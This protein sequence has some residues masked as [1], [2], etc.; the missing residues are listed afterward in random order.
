MQSIDLRQQLIFPANEWKKLQDKDPEKQPGSDVDGEDL[1]VQELAVIPPTIAVLR[2]K[3][4][5]L[6]KVLASYPEGRQKLRKCLAQFVAPK[7]PPSDS[8]TAPPIENRGNPST[9]VELNARGE[10]YS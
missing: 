5:A 2:S 6:R 8:K 10:V 4:N 9:L 1:A 3:R 7:C